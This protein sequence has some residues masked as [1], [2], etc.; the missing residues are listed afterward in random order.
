MIGLKPE[1]TSR[2]GKVDDTC[3][4]RPSSSSESPQSNVTDPESTSPTPETRLTL[5][6]ND[7]EDDID[8]VTLHNIIYYIY[9]KSVNVRLRGICAYPA[10]DRDLIVGHPPSPDPF[11]LYRN[12]KKFLLDPLADYCFEYL[13][14]STYF[15]IL[16]SLFRRDTELKHH[17]K[18]RELF[19]QK[20]VE[21][22]EWVKTTPRWR[23]IVC[24]ELDISAETRQ[25]HE[26]LLFEISQRLSPSRPA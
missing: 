1:W 7:P 12:A 21:S 3:S 2:P 26:Q 19:L 24:N 9:T 8:F 17:D 6:F 15:D 4:T 16:E 22:Y 25:H 23:K 20:L 13:D 5:Y 14:Q 10:N 11:D 18:L